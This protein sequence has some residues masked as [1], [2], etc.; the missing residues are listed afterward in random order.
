MIAR[1]KSIT[2]RLVII[3]A[4]VILLNLSASTQENS[5]T[6]QQVILDGQSSPV[7]AE[8]PPGA[9]KPAL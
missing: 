7:S 2:R 4:S 5:L 9:D 6:A 8:M 1:N 3:F